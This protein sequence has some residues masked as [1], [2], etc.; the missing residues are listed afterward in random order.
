MTTTIP[1][2]NVSLIDQLSELKTLER[3]SFLKGDVATMQ[4]AE[5]L[6]ILFTMI[7]FSNQNIKN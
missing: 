3:N 6:S 4:A 5:S 7:I 2:E 1:N